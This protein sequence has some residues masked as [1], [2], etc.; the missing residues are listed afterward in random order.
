MM[1][2][3]LH[4]W[5]CLSWTASSWAKA[6]ALRTREVGCGL[7]RTSVFLCDDLGRIL[8]VK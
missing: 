6:D 5:K 4:V 8:C 1:I 2:G 3:A 7:K